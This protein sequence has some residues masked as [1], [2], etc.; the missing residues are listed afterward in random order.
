MENP[1]LRLL[2]WLSR[3]RRGFFSLGEEM[4][5]RGGLC[6]VRHRTDRSPP[7]RIAAYWFGASGDIQ[8]GFGPFPPLPMSW[9]CFLAPGHE[10]VVGRF[11]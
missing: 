9:N 4:R 1:H 11:F 10:N 5:S 7:K 2:A 6:P 3:N 8:S